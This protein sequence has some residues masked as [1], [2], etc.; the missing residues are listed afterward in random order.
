MYLFLHTPLPKAQIWH[1][2]SAT[3][4]TTGWGAPR[5][6]GELLKLGFDV[7]Q[8][9]VSKWMPR[10]LRCPV[11]SQRPTTFLRN[12]LD[13]TAAVDFF[14]VPTAPFRQLYSALFYPAAAA[15]DRPDSCSVS[16]PF[17]TP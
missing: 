2:V 9:T 5:I 12:H 16:P 15:S 6:Y 4:L 10:R 8:A 17:T 11:S 7:S 1:R 13:A 14:T 3:L